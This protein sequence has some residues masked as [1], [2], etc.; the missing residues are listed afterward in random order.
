MEA[1]QN[2]H[3]DTITPSSKLYT[4]SALRENRTI[5]KIKNKYKWMKKKNFHVWNFKGFLWFWNYTMNA[6]EAHIM[7]YALVSQEGVT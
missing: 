4:S 5:K 7:N 1:T 2:I 3:I 6:D